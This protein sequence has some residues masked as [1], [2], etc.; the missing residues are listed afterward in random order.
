MK[1]N[2]I[3]RYAFIVLMRKIKR[4]CL[5]TKKFTFPVFIF[6][7][8]DDV[9]WNVTEFYRVNTQTEDKLTTIN[10]DNS[11]RKEE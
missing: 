3:A 9:F 1:S 7:G 11:D 8:V 10:R 5:Q 6:H 2:F 4:E